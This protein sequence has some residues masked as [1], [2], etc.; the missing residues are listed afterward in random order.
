MVSAML[1]SAEERPCFEARGVTKHGQQAN[2]LAVSL[3]RDAAKRPKY[4]SVMCQPTAP[5]PG[6][7]DLPPLVQ[8]KT[9]DA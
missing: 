4:F 8:P 2:T 6:A 7:A 1:R 9:E 3:V 5:Q